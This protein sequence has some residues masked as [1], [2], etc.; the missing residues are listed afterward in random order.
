MS[1]LSTPDFLFAINAS[2]GNSDVKWK[3]TIRNYFTEN[4]VSFSFY[5]IPESPDV[6]QLREVIVKSGAKHVV[7]VGGDGTVTMVAGILS[8]LDKT[9]GILPAGSANGMAKELSIP[10]DPEA[11]MEVLIKGHSRGCDYILVNNKRTCLHMSDIGL[12]AQLI[13]YFDEGQLRGKMGYARMILKT[14]WFKEKMQ[15]IMHTKDL[16]VK[17]NAFMVVLANASKYGTGAVINPEGQLDDGL[18]EVVVVRKLSFMA[19]LRMLIK[20][21]PFNPKHIE[22]FPCTGV[23][24]KTLKKVH[25]QV[26]GEYLGKVKE[27]SAKIVTGKLRLILPPAK[28]K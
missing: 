20:P 27:I 16:E 4:K 28:P 25:F 22:I 14:L 6:Q 12:N 15:V 10:D 2:A 18:F 9:L 7:A 19:L 11:A 23:E 5:D 1:E 8:G 17:R 24:I 21:G 3:D 26:D 13:K